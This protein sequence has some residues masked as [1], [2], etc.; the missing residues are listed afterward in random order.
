MS[1][2]KWGNHIISYKE[3]LFDGMSRVFFA[4]GNVTDIVIDIETLSLKNTAAILSIGAA[5]ITESSEPAGLFYERIDIDSCLDKGMT[6]DADTLAWWFKQP[7]KYMNISGGTGAANALCNLFA[8]M[9]ELGYN[10]DSSTTNIWGNGPEFDNAI[11]INAAYRLLPKSV[12]N[13]M[14]WDYRRNQS[15][16]TLWHINEM[17]GL[18][19]TY[20]YDYPSHVAVFD[21]IVEAKFVGEVKTKL[22]A[23]VK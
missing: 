14:L 15:V 9:T 5:A 19:V 6:I 8:W 16:R 21:A 11:I 1:E 7:A 4:P 22:K 17:L 13:D 10:N 20:K 12:V 3:L 2:W 23:L 18:G